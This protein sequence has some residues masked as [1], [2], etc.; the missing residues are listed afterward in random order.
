MTTL[1]LEAPGPFLATVP[2][3]SSPGTAGYSFGL[4]LQ[5][6]K[7]TALSLALSFLQCSTDT[8]SVRKHV[9]VLSVSTC[10]IERSLLAV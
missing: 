6:Y 9:T 7:P 8:D 1:N 5:T 3:P 2:T 4:N 10:S